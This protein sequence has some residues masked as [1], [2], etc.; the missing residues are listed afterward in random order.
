VT[1]SLSQGGNQLFVGLT[2]ANTG[3]FFEDLLAGNYQAAYVVP[4]GYLASSATNTTF[5]LS[6]GD[7]K[8]LFFPIQKKSPYDLEIQKTVDKA[9]AQP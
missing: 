8:K 7:A 5:T 1:V 4:N 6:E 9:V 2:P 3:I